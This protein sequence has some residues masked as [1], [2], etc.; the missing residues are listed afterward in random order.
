MKKPKKRPI[1][2]RRTW[3]I[4]PKTKVIESKKNYV[5]KLTPNEIREILR[6][7]DL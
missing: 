3:T 7:E 5:H 2:I 4:N 6:T 1:K